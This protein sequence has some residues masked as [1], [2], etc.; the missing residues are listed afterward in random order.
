MYLGLLNEEKREL[1]LDICFCIASADGDYSADEKVLIIRVLN[2]KQ[3][4]MRILWGIS[5]VEDD[6][7]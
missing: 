1:F 6:E 4:Y 3:D 7:E 2:E 5:E